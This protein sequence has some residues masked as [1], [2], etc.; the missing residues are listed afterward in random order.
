METTGYEILISPMKNEEHQQFFPMK[1]VHIQ[2]EKKF[3]TGVL[4]K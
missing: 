4:H 2:R 1:N 3:F